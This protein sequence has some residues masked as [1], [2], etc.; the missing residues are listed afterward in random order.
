[1][2]GSGQWGIAAFTG[3]RPDTARALAEQDCLYTVVQRSDTGDSFELVTSISSAFDGADVA[4]LI[5]LLA[6]SSTSIVTVT[7]TEEG[8]RLTSRGDLDL[9][10]S[11]VAN[12]AELLAGADAAATPATAIGR[13]VAG[14]RARR[15]SGAGPLAVVSCDNLSRNGEL[16]RRA[17]LALA[18]AADPGLADWIDD[19]ISFVSTSVDRITPRTTETD[20]A[21][22]E[23]ECGYRDEAVVVTEPFRD[24]VLSGD[25]PAGRPPWEDAGAV[26]VDDIEPFEN[27]K[28]WM[29][30]GAHSLLAYAGG[31]RG[32]HTVAEAIADPVCL[33]WVEEFWREARAHLRDERLQTDAYRLALLDRFRN[34]RIAHRLTQIAVDGSTKLRMRVVPVVDAER[35]VGRQGAAGL[36]AVA[37]WTAYID[38]VSPDEL[39]DGARHR[40]DAYRAL[41]DEQRLRAL[42]GLVEP[43]W[44]ADDQ[45]VAL[46]R[47]LRQEQ[48]ESEVQK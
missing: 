42:V 37:A 22:V 17:V 11:D 40:I 38:R 6:A 19:S 1:V 28:L 13:L 16:T 36:R 8:Y 18:R 44:A 14:L 39:V 34:A 47:S 33:R 15:R 43:R 45:L 2:D 32:M 35:A 9:G 48:E 41:D 25:F 3:R 20:I 5:E 24:W 4:R 46:V 21:L 10:A 26:F 29:L 7:I 23:R 31:I 27:R 30:N 12:D